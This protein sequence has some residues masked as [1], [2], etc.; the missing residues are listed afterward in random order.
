MLKDWALN[1]LALKVKDQSG[2]TE[3]ELLD[4]FFT[5]KEKKKNQV[6]LA[7]KTFQFDM[8]TV[9]GV[10]YFNDVFIHPVRNKCSDERVQIRNLFVIQF[11]NSICI[12]IN[13]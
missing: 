4:T 12:V 13:R 11:I 6:Y 1:P 8:D 7:D 2:L 5:A 9:K 3:E 10:V